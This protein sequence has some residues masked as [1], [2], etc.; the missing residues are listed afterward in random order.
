MNRMLPLFLLAIEAITTTAL[1]EQSSDNASIIEEIVVTSEFRDVSLMKSA[2]SISIVSLNNLKSGTINHL[3]E[4]LGWTPNVNFAS[5]A[6]RARFIQ[7]RGIGERGQFSEP[8]NSSVGL[9]LDGV[10]MSGIGTVATL[11][12][13]SQVEILRGPQGT[14]YG[15]NAL[16]GLINV[17]SNDPTQIFTAR[18]DMDAGDHDAFGMGAVV[19]G[20]ISDTLGYRLAMRK[21]RDDGFTDNKFLNRDDTNNHDELTVRGKLEWSPDDKTT[22]SFT[23]GKVDVDNGYDAF[24]LDNNRNT[25]SDEPG[26]DK[27]DSTFA[28]VKLSR[29]LASGLTFEGL[30]G[31]ADSEI[32]Y[33][34][35]EDWVFDGFHPWGYSSTDRY[36][37]DR[38]TRTLDMRLLSGES[39]RI[40]SGSTDW[41]AGIYV[42]E[43][44]VDL[45]RQY[46]FNLEDFTSAFNIKRHAVY[47]QLT[48]SL[49]HR[50]R[51]TLGLRAERH[52]A[53][54]RDSS[55]VRSDPTDSMTGGR[56]VLEWDLANGALFYASAT[57]GY[58]AGGFN[59]SGTLDPDL[60]EFDP[61]TLWN[62]EAGLKGLWLDDR[63]SGRLALFSMQR[64]EMQVTTSIE[65]VIPGE[66]AVEFIAFIGNAAE[67]SNTGLEL[68]VLMSVNTQLDLFA[69]F[70]LLHTEFDD[71]TNGSGD[72]LDGRDQA[73]APKYQFHLGGEYVLASGWYLRVEVEGKDDYFFSDSHDVRSDSFELINASLGYVGDGWQAK[74]WGRNLA[75]EDYFVR[76]FFFGNDPRDG[77]TARG[78]TQLGDPRRY[79]LSLSFEL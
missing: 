6:S 56:V 34:Y 28:S 54:Y 24:S 62:F 71:Y 27:Q 4:V 37:R 33:G 16:A 77:Y 9:I 38:T 7:I 31:Y 50:L 57:R 10:D 30:I 25:A 45:R 52:R 40:F 35:D 51:M 48:T 68:E 59:T 3:E 41:V 64:K 26:D 11:F 23:L 29:N 22:W 70:G 53:H 61:E 5:G 74:L 75:N 36:Q 46:T 47:A 2:G 44:D 78:Y 58:K 60:R 43:Q 20:P 42:L 17:V 32:D 15:A 67:G 14:L 39:G 18:L 19:S 55:A 1:A 76:G 21:Y 73:H 63:L 8:L 13:I 12:D 65:R 79:G 49:N 66:N 72:K 69:S